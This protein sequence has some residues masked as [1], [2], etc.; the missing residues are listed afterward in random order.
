VRLTGPDEYFTHQTSLP[1]T[2][3]ASSDPSWRE[4]YWVSMQDV[5]G[6]DTVVTVGMG[7]Y[8]NQDVMEAFACVSRGNMQRNVRLSR[9]LSDEQHRDDPR[10][11]VTVRG[12]VV[13]PRW[14]P[15]TR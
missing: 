8:P 12:G 1:H 9:T 6:G 14:T 3:V 5:V 15:A 11:A 7:K 2:M 13:S 10:D 4:R